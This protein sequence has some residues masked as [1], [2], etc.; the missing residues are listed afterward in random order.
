MM[1]IILI[2]T[3]D[4][5]DKYYGN[6]PEIGEH[7]GKYELTSFDVKESDELYLDEHFASPVNKICNSL[8][9]YGDVDYLD[10][11]KCQLLNSWLKKNI[12]EE[13]NPLLIEIYNKLLELS[14]RAVTLNTGIIIEM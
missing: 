10:A 5:I 1:E 4:G 3:L 11:N 14:A 12:T 8:L 13:N 7:P 2:L 6:I 9:G